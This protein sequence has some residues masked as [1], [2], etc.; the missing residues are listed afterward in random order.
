MALAGIRR[1]RRWWR[2]GCTWCCNNYKLGQVA[3]SIVGVSGQAMLRALSE[4]ARNTALAAQLAAALARL[5]QLESRRRE[6]TGRR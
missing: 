6:P 3:S 1:T 5:E 4:G 2:V